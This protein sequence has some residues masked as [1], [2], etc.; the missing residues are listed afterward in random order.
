MQLFFG[1]LES[2]LRMSDVDGFRRGII[3]CRFAGAVWYIVWQCMQ[4]RWF[5]TVYARGEKE[6]V[7][8][9][10]RCPSDRLVGSS[11]ESIKS[12]NAGKGI[13]FL[14]LHC[15]LEESH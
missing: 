7:V 13:S 5:V 2:K 6:R 4:S 11:P 14:Y 8:G 1:R 15:L 3:V 12:P 9:C 10:V